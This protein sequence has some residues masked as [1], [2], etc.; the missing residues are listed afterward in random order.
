MDWAK[1]KLNVQRQNLVRVVSSDESRF[2]L[3]FA[4]GRME[5]CADTIE[6]MNALQTTV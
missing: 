3:S 1:Q 5:E 2:N 4:D 6:G